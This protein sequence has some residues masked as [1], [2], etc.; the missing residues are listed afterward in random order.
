M[1]INKNR[2]IITLLMSID[3]LLTDE[4]LDVARKSIKNF[5][6]DSDYIIKKG[7][8][9]ISDFYES[10]GNMQPCLHRNFSNDRV[11]DVSALKYSLER[12]PKEISRAKEVHIRSSSDDLSRVE[13]ITRLSCKENKR[14]KRQMYEVGEGYIKIVPV[15]GE[16]DLLDLFT[17]LVMFTREASKIKNL[18][19]NTKLYDQIINENENRDVILERLANR[20]SVS[21]SQIRDINRLLDDEL[22]GTIRNIL[23]NEPTSLELNIDPHYS[24]RDRSDSATR[25]CRN[26]ED[27]I[28]EYDHRP[29]IIISSNTHSVVNCLTGFARDKKTELLAIATKDDELKHVEQTTDGLYFIAQKACK[30]DQR[31]MKSK[32]E[33]EEGLGIKFIKDRFGTGIDIQIID[34]EKLDYT[35]IDPRI[36]IGDSLTERKPIIINIDYAFGKEG[37]SIMRAL[38]EAFNTQIESISITGKAGILCGGKYDIMIPNYILPQIGDG[39]YYFPGQNQIKKNNLLTDVDFGADV[40]VHTGGPMLTVPGTAIQNDRVLDYYCKVYKALGLEMEAGPY[41]DAIEKA[42]GRGLLRDDIKICVGYWGS[43][44]PLDP[45]HSL[46]EKH[47]DRGF[48]PTYALMVA[49]LNKVLK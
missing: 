20:L 37:Y 38:C 23:K 26:I 9:V 27:T 3:H 48:V 25:W 31:M 10:Y 40:K 29:I 44:N 35:K 43:D 36:K 49:I 12:L 2:G 1:T 6:V 24:R 7:H 42:F 22:I 18:V 33:Y 13:G 41:F 32:H 46:A 8:A 16:S 34:T 47:L 30:L 19:Q 17:T 11:I 39:I 21:H 5:C 28:K 45:R 14:N 15:V 4:E